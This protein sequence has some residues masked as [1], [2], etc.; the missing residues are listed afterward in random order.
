VPVP[1]N[2][3]DRDYTRLSN[4]QKAY[5][6]LYNGKSC[7]K[8]PDEYA[9]SKGTKLKFSAAVCKPCASGKVPDAKHALCLG[10]YLQC[11]VCLADQLQCSLCLGE[12]LQCLYCLLWSLPLQVADS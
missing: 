4:K 9:T 1:A 8:C 6:T 2:K 10:E 3:D 11:L 5:D 7:T 12:Y